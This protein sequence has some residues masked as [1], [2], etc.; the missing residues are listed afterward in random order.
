M[1][2]IALIISLAVLF[3]AA[4]PAF[5]EPLDDEMEGVKKALHIIMESLTVLALPC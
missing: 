2:R 1:Q 5:A 4:I 3:A